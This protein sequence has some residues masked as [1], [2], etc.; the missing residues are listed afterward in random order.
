MKD[1]GAEEWV[2]KIERQ[3]VRKS[4]YRVYIRATLLRRGNIIFPVR[5][6]TL[7]ERYLVSDS[8]RHG[9]KRE[10]ITSAIPCGNIERR[11]I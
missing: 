10:K 3:R 7:F 5:I 2:E 8:I 11:A 6:K 4:P 9:F 1:I